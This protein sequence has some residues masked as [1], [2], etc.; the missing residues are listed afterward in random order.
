MLEVEA[1][2]GRLNERG[3]ARSSVLRACPSATGQS[4]G[5]E[6][7]ASTRTGPAEEIDIR[8]TERGSRCGEVIRVKGK[9]EGSK[10][11]VV[12]SAGG[13]H[14]RVSAGVASRRH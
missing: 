7:V 9:G 6:S 3:C 14:A 12:A 10:L 8:I 13:A 1:R 5:V 4:P 2:A 11:A